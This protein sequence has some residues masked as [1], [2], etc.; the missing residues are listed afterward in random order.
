MSDHIKQLV[1][2][3]A[4]N[5]MMRSG[6]FSICTIDKVGSLLCLDVRNDSYKIL[7]V[8]HCVSFSNMPPE[9]R[10]AI[11][12]LINDCL[13]SNDIFQFTDLKTKIIDISPS[14]KAGGNSVIGLFKRLL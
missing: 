5:E 6:F 8:L 4:L 7:S 14:H 12:G 11:P 10:S 1:A 3:T 9:V 13:G 2:I